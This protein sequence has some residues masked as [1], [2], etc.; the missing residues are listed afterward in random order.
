[1][2]TSAGY[3][4]ILEIVRALKEPRKVLRNA[5]ELNRALNKEAIEEGWLKIF[6]TS[7]AVFGLA[8]IFFYL[9][10]GTNPLW[11]MIVSGVFLGISALMLGSKIKDLI[12]AYRAYHYVEEMLQR[13]LAEEQK[14]EDSAVSS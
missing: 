14:R 13:Q 11:V 12:N 9:Y 1:M 5:I 3:E 6:L 8:S 7:L 4:K 10:T 2:N